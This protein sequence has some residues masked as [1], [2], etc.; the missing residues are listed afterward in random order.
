VDPAVPRASC[1]KQNSPGAPPAMENCGYDGAGAALQHL[2][3]G[4]LTP[5]PAGGAA[6]NA[7]LLVRFNQTPAFGAVW[8]GLADDGYAYIPAACQ[9][10]EG[11]GGA[12]CKLHIALHGCGMSASS[13]AMN[14]S[15]ALHAGYNPWA[16]ANGIV[17]LYPQSGGYIQHGTPA[18]APQL[19]AGCWDGYGQT[20]WDYHLRTGPQMVAVRNMIRQVAGV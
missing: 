10:A 1:G 4:R 11:A 8:P 20:G 2:L 9:P 16:E 18:P 15:F 14:A 12:P 19:G 3:S 7:S 5:P 17:V 6:F 13:P